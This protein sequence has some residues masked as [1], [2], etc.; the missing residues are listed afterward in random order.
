MLLYI[1]QHFADVPDMFLQ[2]SCVSMGV[3]QILKEE[4]RYMRNGQNGRVNH[5]L[6][7]LEEDIRFYLESLSN[8]NDAM[9]RSYE[10]GKTYS[11]QQLIEQWREV[12]TE[13]E[14][15]SSI[16]AG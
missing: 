6:S 11:T 5:S 15:N 16:T 2:I 7:D 4:N 3:P 10:L 13:I 12:L 14:E 1:L 9:I 8:W